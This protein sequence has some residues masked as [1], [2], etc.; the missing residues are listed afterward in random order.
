MTC[1]WELIEL[2]IKETNNILEWFLLIRY[3]LWILVLCLSAPY[4][5]TASYRWS[6]PEFRKL[7]REP[8]SNSLSPF[9]NSI[10]I[11]E[12]NPAHLFVVNLLWMLSYKASSCKRPH[13]PHRQNYL[14]FSSLK[15]KQF[16]IPNLER[17]RNLWI[18]FY[19]NFW[20]IHAQ[21]LLS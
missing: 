16:L 3:I 19:P 15:R 2:N 17:Y 20:W 1:Y 9:L 4:S 8:L 10:L 6:N 7:C 21:L 14:L 5:P 11:L 13:G 18:C 12:H